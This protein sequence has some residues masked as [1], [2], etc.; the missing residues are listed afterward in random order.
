MPV[1]LNDVNPVHGG[2]ELVFMR[3]H[4]HADRMGTITA[5]PVLRIVHGRH[6]NKGFFPMTAVN[7]RP[8]ISMPIGEPITAAFDST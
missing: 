1:A 8:R 5:R 2:P 4:L 3:P 6:F 7:V